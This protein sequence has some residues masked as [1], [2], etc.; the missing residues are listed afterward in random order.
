MYLALATVAALALRGVRPRLFIRIA[1][2]TPVRAHSGVGNFAMDAD[3]VETTAGAVYKGLGLLSAMP[4]IEALINGEAGTLILTF[5][6]VTAQMQALA[7]GG[8][9]EAENAVTALAVGFLDRRAQLTGPVLWTTDAEVRRVTNPR[10][11]GRRS[12]E[13]EIAYGGRDRRI[14]PASWL[15]DQDQQARHPGDLGCQWTS[16][17]AA[18]TDDIW[19]RWT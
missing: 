7:A 3:D 11:A 8:A 6:G 19:P 16:K 5:S 9:V 2:A 18:G 14:A 10:E 1:T 4:V 12:V 13:I 17:Y 15:T